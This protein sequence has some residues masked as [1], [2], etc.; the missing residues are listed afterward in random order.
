MT[1]NEDV[2]SCCNESDSCG[3]K[4]EAIVAIDDRGQMVLPKEIREKAKIRPGDKLALLSFEKD[5]S[6]CCISLIKVEELETM[7]KS[8]LGPVINEAFQQ[9]SG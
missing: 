9:S 5:G 1:A 3:C 7:V 4:V 8:R 2:K 6:V